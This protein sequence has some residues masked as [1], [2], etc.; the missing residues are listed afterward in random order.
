MRKNLLTF[1]IAEMA[2][3]FFQQAAVAGEIGRPREL[4]HSDAIKMTMINSPR[5]MYP[6]AAKQNA[7]SGTVWLTSTIDKDGNTKSV[8]VTKSSGYPLLDEAAARAYEQVIYIPYVENGEPI[9][10]SRPSS[11][12]FSL[13][14]KRE[15]P[16]GDTT[17]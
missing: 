4:N 6:A 2:L 11:V 12:K 9:E 15:S 17:K 16:S 14:I 1:L 3:V 8:Q 5:V 10:V 13:S 7:E